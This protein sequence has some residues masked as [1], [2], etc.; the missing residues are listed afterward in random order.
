M[1]TQPI[2]FLAAVCLSAA[3][4]AASAPKITLTGKAQSCHL[5][6]PVRLVGVPGVNVSAFQVSKV[7]LLMTKL[8]EIDTTTI[9]DGVWPVRLNELTKEVDSLASISVAL[10]RAVSDPAGAFTLVIPA[11][12]SVLVYGLGHNEDEPFNQVYTTMSGRANK[13][14][15]LDMSEGGCGP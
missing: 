11:T 3:V 4:F 9:A 15:I 7:S 8:K 6:T 5:G 14:F 10:A 2:P 13:A 12:D 1:S